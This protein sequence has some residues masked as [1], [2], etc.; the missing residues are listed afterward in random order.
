M[1]KKALPTKEEDIS[2]KVGQ[3][4]T[5]L[6][7]TYQNL[8]NYIRWCTPSIHPQILK[9]SDIYLNDF[10]ISL[11][12][13]GNP[14]IN[15]GVFAQATALAAEAYKAEH[16][17]FGV[18]GSSGS[19][20][21]VFRALKH[22][23]GKVK[24]VAQRNIHKS[25][26][27]AITDYEIDVTFI[28]PR[29][30]KELAIVIPNSIEEILATLKNSEA[31]VLLLTN[32]TYE[33]LSLDL[34]K[35]IKKIRKEFP[36]LIVFVDEAWGAHF[37]FSKKLPVCAMEAGA[38]IA[39]HSIHKLG[40]GLQQTSMIHWKSA[41]VNTS[42]VLESYKS[43]TTTSPS[44]HL[45]ASM[46]GT[47][48]FMSQHGSQAIDTVLKYSEEFRED[49]NKIRGL[50]V[51]TLSELRKK[52]PEIPLQADGTKTLIRLTKECGAVIAKELEEKFGIVVEKYEINNLLFIT[53]FQLTH[54]QIEQTIMALKEVL[55]S[56]KKGSAL[57]VTPP[58]L[59]KKIIKHLNPSDVLSQPY[60]T[61]PLAKA[62]GRVAAETIVPYPP[63]IPLVA[64]GEEIQTD[65][66]KYLQECQKHLDWLTVMMID[67]TVKTVCVIKQK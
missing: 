49:L 37:P 57:D 32:P 26:M 10:S 52:Y 12:S 38:D 43:L 16:S 66:V 48:A 30:D 2:K 31:N 64:L 62:V 63:G 13:I 33:G 55:T 56:K 42:F 11:H 21:I 14:L 4:D 35:V 47:R 9:A 19:N 24:L 22:Q 53:T 67:P 20:L 34:P 8:H 58:P 41:L 7:S 36:K 50:K 3:T 15:T 54:S 40:S 23:L 1:P 29:Y 59:P 25:I 60:E 17:L 6:L 65:H 18:N 44:F 51:I 45:L 61:I 28:P 27:V 5:P 39:V 46:D